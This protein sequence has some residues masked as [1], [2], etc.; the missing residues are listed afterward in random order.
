MGLPATPTMGQQGPVWRQTAYI[1]PNVA[2]RYSTPLNHEGEAQLIHPAAAQ[3]ARYTP[4]GVPVYRAPIYPNAQ[5]PQRGLSITAMVLG[6]TS[7]VFAWALVVVPIIGL[8]FG[9]IALRRE[10][11]GRAMAIT[12]LITSGVGLLW[13]LLFYLLP[14]LGVLGV[15]FIG[16]SAA[17]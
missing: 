6:I 15:L 16:M 12:G 3:V 4:Y 10:P 17:P 14:L 7:A 8:V 13:V 5:V 2:Q 9:F 1:A 11:A